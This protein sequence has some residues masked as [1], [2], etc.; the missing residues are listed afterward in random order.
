MIRQRNQGKYNNDN[1]INI[2]E[3]NH[4]FNSTDCDNNI[5]TI[6]DN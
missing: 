3:S 1:N 2:N 4:K 6:Y 5:I